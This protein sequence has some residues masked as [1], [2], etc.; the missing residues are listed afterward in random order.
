MRFAI[1]SRFCSSVSAMS[2]LPQG[3]A[4]DALFILGALEDG[5]YVDAGGVDL[6]GFELA[7]FH[8]LFNFGDDVI[9]GGGHHGIEVARS[10]AIDEIAPAV[11]F[12]GFDESEIAA[13]AAFKDIHPAIE[14]SSLFAFGNHRAVAS[15]C[16]EAGDPGTACAQPLRK[17]TLRIELELQ[18][19]AGHQLLEQFV[20]TNIRGNHLFDLAV[21][22]QHADTEAIDPGIVTRN[23]KILRAFAVHCRYQVLGNAAQAKAAHKDGGTV[24]EIGDGYVGGCDALVHWLALDGRVYRRRGGEVTQLEVRSNETNRATRRAALVD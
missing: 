3:A 16:V 18:F 13:Q 11:A 8:K 15:R 7:D 22:Q 4:L 2:R 20:F 24:F 14:L 17:R 21:L 1:R 10:L 9:G 23:R 5:V 12:P 19:A 6:V